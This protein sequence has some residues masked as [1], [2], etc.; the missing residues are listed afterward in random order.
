[1]EKIKKSEPLKIQFTIPNGLDDEMLFRFLLKRAVNY[2]ET[3]L[4]K[5]VIELVLRQE[6]ESYSLSDNHIRNI[7]TKVKKSIDNL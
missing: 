4:D 2:A 5:K 7:G 3:C 1:M 6:S